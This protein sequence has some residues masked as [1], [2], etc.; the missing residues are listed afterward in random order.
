M[1]KKND[2]TSKGQVQKFARTI[3]NAYQI[4]LTY[5]QLSCSTRTIHLIGTLIGTDGGELYAE[6]VNSLITELSMGGMVQS[7]LDNWDLNSGTAK[8]IGQKAIK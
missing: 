5:L 2:F 6:E 1:R 4:D 3:L 7:S 8:K